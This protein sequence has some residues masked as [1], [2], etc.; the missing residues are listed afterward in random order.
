MHGLDGHA[1]RTCTTKGRGEALTKKGC[2]WHIQG[3][4]AHKANVH[5]PHVEMDRRIYACP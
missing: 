1:W 5:T 2:I 3:A 4:R